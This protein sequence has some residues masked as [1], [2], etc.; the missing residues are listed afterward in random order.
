MKGVG[1]I[2]YMLV[3]QAHCRSSNTSN[4]SSVASMVQKVRLPRQHL[5]H[6][7]GMV[8]DSNVKYGGCD[9]Q[10]GNDFPVLHAASKEK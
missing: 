10:Q 8:E 7:G 3:F 9:Q 1:C 4:T 2:G 6:R 5:Q